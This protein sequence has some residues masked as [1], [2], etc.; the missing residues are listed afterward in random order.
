[1]A[2]GAALV[3]TAALTTLAMIAFAGNSLLCR[4]ALRP[5]LID[6]GT[7][8]SARVLSGAVALAVILRLGTRRAAAAPD[9]TAAAML[10][11]YVACFSFA[12]LSLSAGTGALILFGAV[13]GTMLAAGLRAGERLGP[14]ARG[15][16]LL[17]VGG[18][19]YLV[20]PGLSAPAPWGTALMAGA[21]IA[22]GVYSL[23]GRGGG[24]PLA[25]TAGNFARAV[26]MALVLS[27]LTWSRSHASG[28][29]IA[30]AV[31]SGALTSGA[32]YVIWYAALRGLSATRAAV[33]QLSVPPIAVF[34]G[35]L[36]LDERLSL[37]LIVASAAIL[38]GIGLVLIGRG[39]AG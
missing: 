25:R 21:G 36:L 39:R 8:G 6:P 19:L 31:L 14:A 24:D 2:R 7:F 33:V 3:R 28:A 13:Q 29:G 20:S 11:A 37:R 34:G 10:F 12:Y 32:G 16:L 35:A 18:L 38:G 1:M 23:R 26:P 5:A 27:A 15:G 4:M 22:W 17:A 9:W 30:L